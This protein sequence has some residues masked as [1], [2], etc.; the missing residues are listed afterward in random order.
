MDWD[1]LTC[2]PRGGHIPDMSS[3]PES[4]PDAPTSDSPLSQAQ[5]EELATAM[6]RAAKILGAAKVAAFTGWTVMV[7][8]LL[9]LLLTLFSPTGVLLGGALLMVAWN[10]LE[11]RKQIQRFHEGGPRRLARNQLWLLAVIAVYC[12]WSIYQARFYPAPGL[13]E[14]EELLDLGEGF[15]A[16]ATTAAYALV[17]AVATAFQ[18]GMYRYHAARIGLLEEYVRETPAWIVEIQRIVRAG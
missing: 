17:L 18:L 4:T 14:M 8:G 12:L 9:T 11:G 15:V 16:G 10:E 7:C 5:I 6:H 1:R 13:S 2:L 3:Q